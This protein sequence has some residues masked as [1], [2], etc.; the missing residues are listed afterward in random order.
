MCSFPVK[1]NFRAVITAL[2]RKKTARINKDN[3]PSLDIIK[4]QPWFSTTRSYLHII[5]LFYSFILFTGPIGCTA[6]GLSRPRLLGSG[7]SHWSQI[8][9][10]RL[11][12]YRKTNRLTMCSNIY[13]IQFYCNQSKQRGCI[14]INRKH[15]NITCHKNNSAQGREFPGRV[16]PTS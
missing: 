15:L 4:T 11:E 1:K 2:L 14:L 16:Q 7:I 9:S 6:V 3:N 5:I 8:D 10:T 13:R 12:V